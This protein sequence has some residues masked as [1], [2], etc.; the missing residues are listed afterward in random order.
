M[1]GWLVGCF[2]GCFVG[3]TRT[4]LYGA[5]WLAQEPLSLSWC[6]REASALQRHAKEKSRAEQSI[7]FFQLCV[8]KQKA[9]GAAE[10]VQT[11]PARH[12][13]VCVSG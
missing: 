13:C 12:G 1:A 4:A 9:S 8:L 2:V 3:W 10:A 5:N 7:Y 11:G 6:S